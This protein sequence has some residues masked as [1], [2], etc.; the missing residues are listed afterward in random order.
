MR[1]ILTSFILALAAPTCLAAGFL[2][3]VREVYVL[4]DTGAMNRDKNYEALLQGRNFAVDRSRGTVTG[5]PLENVYATEIRVLA[6]GGE[7]SAFKVLSLRANDDPYLLRI[8]VFVSGNEKP[9][10]GTKGNEIFAGSCR[11]I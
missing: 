7:S 10:I 2:C 4:T 5:I 3:T 9:F 8:D 1:R 11:L 6:Q